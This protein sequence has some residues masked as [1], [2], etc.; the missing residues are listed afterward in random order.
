M[1]DIR[2][3]RENLEDIK[4][5]MDDDNKQYYEISSSNL[6]AGTNN[7]KLIPFTII[8]RIGHYPK[9]SLGRTY[10][11]ENCSLVHYLYNNKIF[12]DL[13]ELVEVL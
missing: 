1:L 9:L 4:K 3:I 11:N 2:R 12:L 5:A 6:L 10:T 13:V 8:S 7:S